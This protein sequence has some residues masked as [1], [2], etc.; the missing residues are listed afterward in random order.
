MYYYTIGYEG[1]SRK[2]GGPAGRPIDKNRQS[3]TADDIIG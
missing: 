1:I 3:Q 2:K